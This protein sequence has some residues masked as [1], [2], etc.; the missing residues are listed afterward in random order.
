M[1]S[2]GQV[3]FVILSKKSQIYPMQVIE[4]ITKKTLQ[5]EEVSYVV[6]GGSDSSSTV[7][8]DQVDGEIFETAEKARS[9]LVD[10]A[11]N[12]INKLVD[13]ATIKAKEWYESTEVPEETRTIENLPDLSPRGAVNQLQDIEMSDEAET[14]T[15]VTL[16]DGTVAKI[17]MPKIPTG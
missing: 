2:I 10:R 5:G 17:K 1:Y 14:V 6:Q 15:V 8:L 12:H 4:I 11:T 7:M 13:A 3:I 16:P 9:T